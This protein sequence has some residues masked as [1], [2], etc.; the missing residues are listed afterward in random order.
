MR[1]SIAI[2]STATL[3]ARIL[4]AAILISPLAAQIRAAASG[5]MGVG[6]SARPAP[7][8][9]GSGAA[10]GPA[11]LHRG[12]PSGRGSLLLPYP[13][14]YSTYANETEEAAPPPVIVVPATAP[15]SALPDLPREP[16]L[17]EWQ[18]DHF[19][20]MTPFQKALASG[21]SARGSS[22]KSDVRS[23]ASSAPSS[24]APGSSPRSSFARRSPAPPGKVPAQ[25]QRELPPAVLVFRDGRT[26]EVSSYIIASGIIYSKAD[27]W[28]S[29]TWTREIQIAD[30]DVPATLRLNHQH[31][32]N[33]MLPTSPNEVVVRP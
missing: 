10:G 24:S 31:G 9:V 13:Y 32:L 20:R 30:L 18:G 1:F 8:F 33:F 2:R 21:P 6:I 22:D 5:A 25:P 23:S 15:A 16:L 14:F 11:H 28:T 26:E 17:I 19:E 12:R 7:G 4:A 29:G 3:A 27:Y